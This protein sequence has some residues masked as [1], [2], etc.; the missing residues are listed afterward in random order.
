VVIVEGIHVLSDPSF[1]DLFDLSVFVD[2]PADLRLIRRIRRDETERGRSAESVI[3]QY[4]RLRPRSP[5]ALHGSRASP[6]R[7]RGRVRSRAT[8]SRWAV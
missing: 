4:L 2:A 8:R 3:Q 5:G 1:V 6:V 7:Y